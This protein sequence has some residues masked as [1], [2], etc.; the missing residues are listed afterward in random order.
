MSTAMPVLETARL[1]IRPFVLDDLHEVQRVLNAAWGEAIPLA[2][3]EAWLRWTIAGYTQ[4]AALTQ[5]PYGDRAIVLRETGALVG[6]A[7]LVPSLGPFGLLPS[8][9]LPLE[10]R[11]A[12][13]IPEVGLYWATDPARQGHGFATEAARALADWAFAHLHLRRIVATT[14]H[15]NAVSQA[16]MRKLGMSIEANPL[17]EPPWFQAVGVLEP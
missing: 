9:G 4:L 11:D 10:A 7:G 6:V 2:E 12:R 1:R 17:L 3:R 14:E 5:P 13:F 8:S 15:A 16:V